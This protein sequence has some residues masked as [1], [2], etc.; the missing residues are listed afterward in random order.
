MVRLKN[1]F[2]GEDGKGVNGSHTDFLPGP[3]WNYNSIVKI[4]SDIV[5]KEGVPIS[6]WAY[7]FW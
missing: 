2:Q 6:S 4:T 3:I 1:Y 7:V 5:G